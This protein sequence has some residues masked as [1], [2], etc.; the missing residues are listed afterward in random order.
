M[1]NYSEIIKNFKTTPEEYF[2]PDDFDLE[3]IKI[4]QS[5]L[6]KETNA[7]KVSTVSTFIETRAIAEAALLEA[8]KPYPYDLLVL[9]GF[10]RNLTPYFID[11]VNTTPGK[12]RI[13][14]IHPAIL[15]AFPG[16][17]GIRRH[18]STRLQGGRV[19]SALY[20][21]W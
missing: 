21:L 12:P 15:P 10:M 14:N 16:V 5:L 7:K 11:R 4:K 6:D 19:H 13:M 3:D 1:V 17:D 2:F 9:A 8:M 18:V 20:R